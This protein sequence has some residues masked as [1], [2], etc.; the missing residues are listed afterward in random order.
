MPPI[1]LSTVDSYFFSVRDS[2]LFSQS[3]YFSP[4][5]GIESKASY[6]LISP[7]DCP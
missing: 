7:V 6:N 3:L 5:F 4:C 1:I 2:S